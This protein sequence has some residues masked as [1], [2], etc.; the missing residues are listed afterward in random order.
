[1]NIEEE[2]LE[3]IAPYTINNHLIVEHN[4][5][6]LINP[7]SKKFSFSG[8]KIDWGKTRNHW[9]YNYNPRNKTINTTE[10]LEIVA[11]E[12]ENKNF[13]SIIDQSPR[14]FYINDSSL[15]FGLIISRNIFWDVF[16]LIIINTPQHHYF[17]PEDGSW[18]LAIT[19][20]GFVDYGESVK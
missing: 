15:D 18:C 9:L 17:F 1:M 8:S 3:K 12:L 2:I 5:E 14:I 13:Q 6:K 19:M 11:N 4:Q 10:K 7:L 20:E 16:R